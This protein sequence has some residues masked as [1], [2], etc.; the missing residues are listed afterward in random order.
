MEN[1][2]L[3]IRKGVHTI[4][5][6]LQNGEYKGHLF[7]NIHGN[8]K[9]A[10]I[11]DIDFYDE[12]LENTENDCKLTYD[13]DLELYSLELKNKQGDVLICDGLE[14]EELENMVVCSEIIDFAEEKIVE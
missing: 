1:Y 9:G 13:E 14:A 8:C 11:L 10:S 6:T 7:K 4:K 5:I 12:E 3:N 2:N